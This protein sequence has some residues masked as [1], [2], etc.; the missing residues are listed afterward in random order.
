MAINTGRDFRNMR[1]IKLVKKK[2]KILVSVDYK[3]PEIIYGNRELGICHT[4]NEKQGFED[5]GFPAVVSAGY[6]VY[7]LKILRFEAVDGAKIGYL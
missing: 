5:S 1:K 2:T 3:I 6:K 4:G 7:P